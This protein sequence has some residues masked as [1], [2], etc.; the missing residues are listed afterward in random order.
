MSYQSVSIIVLCF[1]RSIKVLT[2]SRLWTRAPASISTII[3]SELKS[4]SI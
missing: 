1:I 3:Y 2:P 4:G